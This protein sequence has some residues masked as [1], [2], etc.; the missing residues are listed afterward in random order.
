[1]G[2]LRI[3]PSGAGPWWNARRA[4]GGPRV[5]LF[6]AFG[7]FWAQ[8]F[9]VYGLEGLG[10]S[11]LRV[12]KGLRVKGVKLPEVRVWGGGFCT[13]PFVPKVTLLAHGLIRLCGFGSRIAS[14]SGLLNAITVIRSQ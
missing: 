5:F 13:V 4:Q 10:L 11:W 3:L 1:M 8:A 14:H 7:D 2:K 9:R 12:L 6:G